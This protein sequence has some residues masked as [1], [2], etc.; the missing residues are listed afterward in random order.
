MSISWVVKGYS[1]TATSS[2]VDDW[3]ADVSPKVVA[4]FDARLR[5]LVSRPSSQ[6]DVSYAHH[7]KGKCD[8]LFEIRFEVDNIAYRP[9]CCFGPTRGEF[10]IVLFAIEHNDKLRPPDACKTGLTRKSEI[11]NGSNT[12]LIYDD[13]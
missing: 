12:P 6:W 4:K 13:Y 10:T 11:E 9:L 5:Y 8:G 7:L 1:V 2:A 3:I